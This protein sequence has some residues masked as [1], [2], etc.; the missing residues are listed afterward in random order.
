MN[1]ITESKKI[2]NELITEIINKSTNINHL[3]QFNSFINTLETSN[4]VHSNDIF[5]VHKKT[6]CKIDIGIINLNSTIL[7]FVENAYGKLII[8]EEQLKLAYKYIENC[9]INIKI[10]V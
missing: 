7:S 9:D 1:N 2:I 8:G 4:I 10:N 6:I 5:Q 3:K